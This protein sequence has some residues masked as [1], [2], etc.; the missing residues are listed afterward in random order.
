MALQLKNSYPSITCLIILLTFAAPGCSISG[1][2]GNVTRSLIGRWKVDL[3]DHTEIV[4]EFSADGT[5]TV[6]LTSPI[7]KGSVMTLRYTLDGDRLTETTESTTALGQGR[8]IPMRMAATV[9]RVAV[10]NRSLIV[11]PEGD[12]PRE[13]C[14]YTRF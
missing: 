12:T 3:R 8:P 7:I 2:S 4:K 14:T 6:V 13:S 11:T 1:H 10:V 5:E 9:S